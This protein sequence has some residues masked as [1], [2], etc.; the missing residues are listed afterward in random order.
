MFGYFFVT[1]ASG[2]VVTREESKIL[3]DEEKTA[4]KEFIEEN[5]EY[6]ETEA[7]EIEWI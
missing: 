1:K 5:I 7:Y 6:V 3:V 4:A 2:S